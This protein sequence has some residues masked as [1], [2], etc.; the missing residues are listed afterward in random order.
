[1]TIAIKHRT[2]AD[3]L[4]AALERIADPLD[5]CQC[6]DYRRSHKNGSG[7]CGLCTWNPSNPFNPC[8]KFRLAK[9]AVQS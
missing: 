2:A 6:G 9:K 1:M 8:M 4:M 5:E 7:K 3:A